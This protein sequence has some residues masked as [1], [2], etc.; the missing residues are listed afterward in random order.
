MDWVLFST[1]YSAESVAMLAKTDLS[2]VLLEHRGAL[3][4]FSGIYQMGHSL[5]D[6]EAAKFNFS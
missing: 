6:M 4:I 2:Q 1:G 5:T 3:N